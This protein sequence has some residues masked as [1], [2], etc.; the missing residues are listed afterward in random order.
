MR[1]LGFSRAVIPWT[2][3]LEFYRKCSGAEPAHRFAAFAK[4]L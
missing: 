1:R 3:A 2:D 4:E